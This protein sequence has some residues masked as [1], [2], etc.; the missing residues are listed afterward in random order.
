MLA[1]VKKLKCS[2]ITLIGLESSGKTTFFSK[3]TNQ[4]IGEESNVKGSTYSVRIHRK[5][6]IE[7]VDTPGIH[8]NDTLANEMVKQELEK[9]TCIVV[10]VRGTH[11]QEELKEIIPYLE[12]NSKST[13][14][15]ATYADKMTKKS[16]KVLNQTSLMYKLPLILLDARKTTDEK[17]QTFYR[18]VEKE[19]SFTDEKVKKLQ[20]L[21]LDR[22]E[23]SRLIFDIP[24][25]GKLLSF[26]VLTFMFLVP[27]MGAY[28]FADA[29][30]PLV[31]SYLISSMEAKLN[32]APVFIYSI[33]VG[34]YGVFSLGIYSFLWAFP[35]VFLMGC[36]TAI[37]D[38][39]G[40]K[41]RIVDTLDPLLRN[42]GLNGKDL[43]P[44]LTGFGCN[45]VA[46]F[47][48]RNCSLCTRK[49]CI[50][51]IT[52][53][54]ACSY[55]IGATLSIFNS[56]QKPW[57]I[58]PY[59]G[60]LIAGGIFH[61]RIWNRKYST[62][63]SFSVRKTF[64]QKPTINGLLFRLSSDIKQFCRQALPI[65]LIICVIAAIFHEIGLLQVLS[66][67]FYPLLAIFDIPLAAASG[68]AFS[69]I[70]K[71]GILLFNEGQ[72]ELLVQL[73]DFQLVLLVFLA[74]TLTACVV[75]MMTIWKEIGAK[76]ALQ[77]IS[78]QLITSLICTFFIYGI[79]LFFA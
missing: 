23:P 22:V 33:L 24:F 12:N 13:I 52:F 46:V 78:K 18:C 25:F 74:S 79:S 39:T 55:Q 29:L 62:P 5:N 73:D 45:V 32:H 57:L 37:V 68:L 27:V 14:I 50:S 35:V 72:G 56:A 53:G 30:T 61:T 19:Y 67:V 4:A 17:L 42:I 65:F 16:K 69:I 38:E 8:P 15:V 51:F 31:N 60:L 49:Q 40:L 58:F 76:I 36:T 9:A 6:N 41:D 70:R 43:I 54:S 77:L 59:L 21:S 63:P 20:V 3:L 2:T 10:I 66:F 44:V 48:S 64:L 1:S 26:L 11:L 71:D 7:Y 75:T 47:Q 28:Y 34:D